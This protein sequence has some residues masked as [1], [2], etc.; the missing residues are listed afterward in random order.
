[1]Q[2]TS[3]QNGEYSICMKGSS[4]LLNLK[5]NPS[6]EKQQII[7]MIVE[8]AYE[9][10]GKKLSKDIVGD[11][12]DQLATFPRYGDYFMIIDN[13][14]HI[15]SGMNMITYE[16]NVR[17]NKVVMWIQT[18]FVKEEYRMKGFFRKLLGENENFVKTKS[19]ESEVNKTAKNST[20][21]FER[22]IKLYMDVDNSK[23]EQVYYKV[24]FKVTDEI[25]YE[26]DYNFDDIKFLQ[27][28]SHNH[29]NLNQIN[30]EY[31]FGLLGNDKE[32]DKELVLNSSEEEFI[33]FI[34]NDKLVL[35][36]NIEAIFRVIEDRTLGE[37]V[38]IYDYSNKTLVGL[39]YIFFEFSDWRNSLFWWVGDFVVNTKCQDFVLINMDSIIYTLVKINYDLKRCGLRF[40]VTPESQNLLKSTVLLKSH[41]I[42][43]EKTLD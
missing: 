10:E 3:N 38:Y 4:S 14:K 5:V 15:F 19:V 22:S 30:S 6:E 20:I 2:K 11:A 41:Y 37:V 1:M 32:K 25:L 26:L 35:K 42:I 43:Y 21:P 23:A 24:G 40:I 13:N 18:V 8:M 34:K 39:F 12:L 29:L 28:N 16:F 9:S 31:T 27:T 36:E 7:D 33:S 17:R